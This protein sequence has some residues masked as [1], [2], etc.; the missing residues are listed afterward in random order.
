MAFL[1]PP[2]SQEAPTDLSLNLQTLCS[3][4]IAYSVS[5]VIVYVC[6]VMHSCWNVM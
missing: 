4:I 3:V 2:L 1:L 5:I 6:I